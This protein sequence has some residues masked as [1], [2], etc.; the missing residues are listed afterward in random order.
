M[1]CKPSF[2]LTAMTYADLRPPPQQTARTAAAV[3]HGM[4]GVTMIELLVTLSISA[5]LLALAVPSFQGF[6]NSNRVLTMSN[7]LV[8]ALNLARSEAIKRGTRITI[9]KCADPNATTPVCS[10]A[11]AWQNGWLVFTDGGTAGTV[12]GSDTRL[13]VGQ[14]AGGS[15]SIGGDSNF[16]NYVSYLPSGA[17]LGNGGSGSGTLSICVAGLLRSIA[18]SATGRIL[19]GQGSC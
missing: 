15:G 19:V 9:C 11:A 2:T 1:H 14:A 13:R 4:R 17:S 5:I 3:R 16:S 10:T 12:D 8:S 7:D 6:M 18:V